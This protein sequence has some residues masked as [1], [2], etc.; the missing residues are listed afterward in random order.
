MQKFSSIKDAGFREDN[1]NENKWAI[2]YWVSK[3]GFL[4]LCFYFTS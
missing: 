4:K 2:R 1:E 3:R